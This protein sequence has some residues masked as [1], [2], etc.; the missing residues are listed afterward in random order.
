V[1]TFIE[2]FCSNDS[3]TVLKADTVLVLLQACTVLTD[4]HGTARCI[5]M[6]NYIVALITYTDHCM[7]VARAE[8]P[9]IAS[10]S[11]QHLELCTALARCPPRLIQWLLL[12]ADTDELTRLLQVCRCTDEPRLLSAI[13]SLVHVRTALLHLLYPAAPYRCLAE[14]LLAVQRTELSTTSTTNSSNS[15]DAGAGGGLLLL[16]HIGN[17][18][19]S[20]DAIMALFLKEELSTAQ[21]ALQ[22]LRVFAAAGAFVLRGGCS[23]TTA[24]RFETAISTTDSNTV[25]V[26]DDDVEVIEIDAQQ[27][28]QQQQRWSEAELQDLRA[29]LLLTELSDAPESVQ[30]V[31]SF[32]AHLQVLSEARHCVQQLQAAGHPEFQAQG[33]GYVLRRSFAALP[34]EQSGGL[35]GV[36]DLVAEVKQLRK[37]ERSWEREMLA[38][39]RDSPWLDCFTMR[40][41]DSIVNCVYQ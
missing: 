41:I 29:K 17:V 21:Q 2:V 39:R 28:Q 34:D 19:A 32:D 36:A 35:L 12:H 9:A 40:Y 11:A 27:Q 14:L 15:S 24:L 23:E 20:F 13:A 8:P 33:S 38:L 25:S 4:T 31:R 30:L 26:D 22:S 37:L 1:L 10:C 3:V 18:S 16:Q 5:L 6:P 7:Q